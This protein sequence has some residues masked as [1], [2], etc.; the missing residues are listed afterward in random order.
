[1]PPNPPLALNTLTSARPYVLARILYVIVVVR[2]EH[3]PTSA[4]RRSRCGYGTAYG[5]FHRTK[6]SYYF[7]SSRSLIVRHA[8]LI[9]SKLAQEGEHKYD[10]KHPVLLAIHEHLNGWQFPPITSPLILGPALFRSPLWYCSGPVRSY[11]STRTQWVRFL[12]SKSLAQ[13]VD[14]ILGH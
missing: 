5:A 9:V 12:F 14:F 13:F 7:W 10:N 11:R 1:M 6:R 8:R 2:A 4:E 3:L